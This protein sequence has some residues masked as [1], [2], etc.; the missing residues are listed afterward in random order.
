MELLALLTIRILL[1]LLAV[2][3]PQ[4]KSAMLELLIFSELLSTVRVQ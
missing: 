1:E 3:A 4:A 2:S